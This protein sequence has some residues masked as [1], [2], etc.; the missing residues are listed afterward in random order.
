MPGGLQ[1][2]MTEKVHV[3]KIIVENK[4]GLILAVRESESQKWELP[5]GKIKDNEDRFEAAERELLEETGLSSS[6]FED[7][8][9]VEV[10]DEECVNCH[11][12]YTEHHGAG[13]VR[14]ESEELDDFKWVRPKD[15]KELNWHADSGYGIPAV[16]KLEEY[17]N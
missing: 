8:V 14:I 4:E 1:L 16:E 5:G 2:N 12:V 17:M 15:Y 9:R 7:V 10:E 3:V 6:N 13:S 11:I